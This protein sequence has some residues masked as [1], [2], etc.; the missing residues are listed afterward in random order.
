MYFD[1]YKNP[2]KNTS[3]FGLLEKLPLLVGF[4]NV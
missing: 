4:G 1:S 2:E 3:P